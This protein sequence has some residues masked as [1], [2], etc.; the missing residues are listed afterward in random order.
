V[1]GGLHLVRPSLA[2]G[3]GNKEISP[4]EKRRDQERLIQGWLTSQKQRNFSPATITSAQRG[5]ANFLAAAGKFCWEITVSDVRDYHD[6]LCELGLEVTTRRGYLTH[7][8]QFFAFI[9]AHPDIPLTTLEVQAGLPAER[10]DHKYSVRLQQPVDR[11]Y[12]PVHVTDD[13]TCKRTTRA[14]PTKDEMR[15]Y[16]AFL[17]GRIDPSHK[18]IPVA[19][20]YAMFRF[21][22]H[23]GLRENEVAMVDLKDV[24][25]DLGT[26]HCRIGKGSGGAGPRERSCHDRKG[27]LEWSGPGPAPRRESGHHPIPHGRHGAR[28]LTAKSRAPAD[29]GCLVYRLGVHPLG[30]ARIHPREGKAGPEGGSR[31]TSR[32]LSSPEGQASTQAVVPRG[33]LLAHERPSASL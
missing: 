20:D 8:K 19:R 7:I 31:R 3:G 9:E 6:I 22:Y 2:R 10:V 32:P 25:F 27:A 12:M 13:V 26:I 15:S 23:T 21:L 18:G 5:V 28:E 17:R 14:L 29:A 1:G 30:P 24:R 16:F 33:G 4:E 11:W